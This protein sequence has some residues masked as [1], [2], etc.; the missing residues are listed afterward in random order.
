M[1]VALYVTLAALFVL[2]SCGLEKV[3]THIVARYKETSSL[4]DINSKTTQAEMTIASTTPFMVSLPSDPTTGHLWRLDTNNMAGVLLVDAE[5]SGEFEETKAETGASTRQLFS[6]VSRQPPT[7][8]IKFE[9][10]KPGSEEPAE[11]EYIIVV[12]IT[13]NLNS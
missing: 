8:A 1:K 2:S 12:T 6:L 9:Y 4:P 11:A 13:P 3:E 5:A 7:G 10:V